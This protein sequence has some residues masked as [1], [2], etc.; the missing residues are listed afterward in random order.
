MSGI[1]PRGTGPFNRHPGYDTLD[2]LRHVATK[3]ERGKAR[4][5]E[6]E[7]ERD[8]LIARARQETALSLRAIGDIAGVSHT[9]VQNIIDEQ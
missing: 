2:A 3:I 9:Q 1:A 4:I 6:L 5:V 8:A 7:A